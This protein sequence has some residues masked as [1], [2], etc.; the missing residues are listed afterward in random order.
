MKTSG[1]DV[2]RPIKGGQEF[3]T[4]PKKEK[5]IRME[6]KG[7]AIREWRFSDC[8]SLAFQANNGKIWENVMDHFPHPYTRRDAMNYIRMVRA[9]PGPP[10]RFA[11]EIDGKAAGSIGFSSEGDIE[12]VTAEIG[13]W[14][15]E[16]YWGR[17]IMSGVVEQTARYAFATFPFGKLFAYV[18]DYNTASMKVLEHAGFKLEAVL[19][20][21]AIKNNRLIDF[22][23][24]SKMRED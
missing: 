21:A 2:S 10:M 17:G 5:C 6:G 22:Y 14:L 13:Y 11:I 3:F 20:K 8:E 4:W 7:Y 24:F 15:G 1:I 18:F 9:M 23:Y 12:R 16:E 19:H